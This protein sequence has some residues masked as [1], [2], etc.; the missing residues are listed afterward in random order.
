ML[1][2]SGTDTDQLA[3]VAA[4]YVVKLAS[5]SQ[6]ALLKGLAGNSYSDVQPVFAIQSK[7]SATGMVLAQSELLKFGDATAIDPMTLVAG[8]ALVV[9]SKVDGAFTS[10]AS[11]IAAA[12]DVRNTIIVSAVHQESVLAPII[13]NKNG[14]HIVLE[15]ADAPTITFQLAET[16]SVRDLYL[17]G[18]GSADLIGNAF[19]NVLVGSSGQNAIDGR[20]GNDKLLGM[21]GDD[22]L[23]GGAGND[24]LDG[25]GGVD[26]LFGGSGDDVLLSNDDVPAGVGP[27]GPTQMEGDILVGGSGNDVLIA[28][29]AASESAPVRMMEIGRAHV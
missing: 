21:G 26:R 24:W 18:A 9:N 16:A 11:A 13:V 28:M 15:N 29:N 27:M 12:T 10:I 14:L 20:G 22:E 4:D 2:R 7:A 5:A 1:F 19:D 25:G 8:G 6:R 23:F 3:G 17:F